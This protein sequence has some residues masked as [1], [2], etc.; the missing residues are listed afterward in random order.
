MQIGVG[1]R[2]PLRESRKSRGVTGEWG[3]N[4]NHFGNLKVVE[5]GGHESTDAKIMKIVADEVDRALAVDL[6]GGGGERQ[7]D[8]LSGG[9]DAKE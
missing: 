4:E 9:N 1:S 7:I 6:A 8:V 2:F 3:K 5:S